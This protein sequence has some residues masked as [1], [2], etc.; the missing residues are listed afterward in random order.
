VVGKLVQDACLQ[1]KT[2][3]TEA[4]LLVE[5]A[6]ALAFRQ[7]CQAYIARLGELR[8]FAKYQQPAGIDWDDA[9][10]VGDA[11]A[12]YAWAVY[13]AE[14]TV[15]LDTFEVAVDDFTTVQEVGRVVHPILAAGQIEGGVAQGVGF[16]LYEKIVWREGRMANGRM[17]NYIVPTAAD[18][19]RIHVTFV[20]KDSPFGPGRGAKGIGELPMDGTAPAVANSLEQAL[21]VQVDEIP[22]TPEMLMELMQKGAAH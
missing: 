16:A 14:V 7:A 2:R 3:L 9:K 17:T 1:L 13:V 8:G 15:D 12:T 6:S 22:V 19:P 11:Y 20:E 10:Y 5:G 21:G 4:G 18:A